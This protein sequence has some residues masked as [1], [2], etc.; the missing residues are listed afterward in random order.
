MKCPNC[1][2]KLGCGCQKRTATDGKQCCTNCLASYNKTIKPAPTQQ[3]GNNNLAPQV[4]NV[5]I[6]R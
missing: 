6:R 2:A 5:T 3:P 4:N 1:G